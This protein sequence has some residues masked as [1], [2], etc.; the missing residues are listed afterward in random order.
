MFVEFA[1]AL[2]SNTENLF[3]GLVDFIG[4]LWNAFGGLFD[5]FLGSSLEDADQ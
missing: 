3:G 4:G 2:S 1:D 5:G